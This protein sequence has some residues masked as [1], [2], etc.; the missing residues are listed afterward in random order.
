MENSKMYRS[1]SVDE[2]KEINGGLPWRPILKGLG[3]LIA[4]TALA[5]YVEKAIEWVERKF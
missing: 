2:M 1:L 4:E 3:R 5:H